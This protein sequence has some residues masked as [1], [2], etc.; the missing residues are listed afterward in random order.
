M[1]QSEAPCTACTRGKVEEWTAGHV[2]GFTRCSVCGG[3][4]VA[5]T[6]DRTEHCRRIGAQGGQTTAARHGRWHMSAI[7]KAGARSTIRTHGVGYWRGLM[8]HKGYQPRRPSLAADLAYGRAL[9]A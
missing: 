7:G 9:A 8:K 1:P 6:F 3:T 4:G 5:P 2:S